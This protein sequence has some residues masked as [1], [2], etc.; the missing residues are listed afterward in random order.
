MRYIGLFKKDRKPISEIWPKDQDG[1][2]EKA[3]FLCHLSSNDMEDELFINMLEA[4]G[5]PA[6]RQH[7]GDG[8]FGK[9]ILGMSGM[10][11]DLYVPESM[12]EDALNLYNN[13]EEVTDEQLP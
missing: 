10:G 8:D 3:V 2:N 11:T 5:I 9:V 1:N 12:V 13:T 6:V 7:P 4:Y